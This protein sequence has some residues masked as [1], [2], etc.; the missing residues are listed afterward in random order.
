MLNFNSILLFSENPQ[1]LAEFYKQ[2]VGD[3]SKVNTTGYT[4]FALMMALGRLVG[5]KLVDRFGSRNV[6]M[7]DSLFIAMGFLI[8]TNILNSIGVIIGF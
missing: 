8:G 6:L 5:D 1:R 4:A 2:V 3:G 7:V